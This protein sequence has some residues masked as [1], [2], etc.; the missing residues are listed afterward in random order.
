MHFQKV[1]GLGND[2]V[3]LDLRGVPGHMTAARAR[4]LCDRHTG[5]GGDGVLVFTGSPD[6][7]V[8]TI[9]NPD[10]TIPEMCGNGIRCF[11][12]ELVR[13][14][15]VAADPIIVGTG[16][17]PLSCRWEDRG[18]AGFLVEVDMGAGLSDGGDVDLATLPGLRDATVSPR[19][20]RG[21]RISI[22]NP[23]VVFFDRFTDAE[24]RS[25][26][27]RVTASAAF[28]AGVNTEFAELTGPGR[29]RLTVHERGAGFT[30]ACGTGACAT[31]AAGV[32]AGLLESDRPVEVTLPGGVLRILH[33]SE[34]G[35]LLMTGPAV[36]VFEGVI[37]LDADA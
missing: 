2:F 10:G 32:R 12:M 25:W 7:P 34:D 28:P 27:P 30:L 19:G 20:L 26:G 4:A 35:H 36:E 14:F 22:G 24:V 29:I 31:V 17:G 18:E 21:Q 9:W 33:R 16:A 8:M 3:F 5:V 13:R 6:E 15:G 1:H 11:V 23:H 37:A